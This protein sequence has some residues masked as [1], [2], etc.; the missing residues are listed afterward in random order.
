LIRSALAVVVLAWA[1]PSRADGI[2]LAVGTSI[3]LTC[4]T[5]AVA[6]VPEAKTT[7][8]TLKLKIEAKD[9]TDK[10]LSGTWLI[11]DV[12]PQ[13][14]ASFAVV[15]AR[16]CREGCPLLMSPEATTRAELWAPRRAALDGISPNLPLTV[17]AL[18]LTTKTLRVSTFLDKQIAS[19]E[20]GECQL[21][22]PTLP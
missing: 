21:S 2:V 8:G 6:V 1:S 20:Q 11:L 4:E 19:L 16:S 14:S 12:A 7:A 10:G 18:D 3:E 15:Q 22:P 9:A 5:K 13:H 17:A